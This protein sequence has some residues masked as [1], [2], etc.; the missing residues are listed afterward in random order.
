MALGKYER[1]L[2]VKSWNK[3]IKVDLVYCSK[4]LSTLP[5]QEL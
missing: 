3:Q 1:F 5:I 4:L 2:K